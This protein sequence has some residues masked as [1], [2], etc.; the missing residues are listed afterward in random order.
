MHEFRSTGYQ[1]ARTFGELST[2][3]LASFELDSDDMSE[4]FVKQ[5]YGNTEPSIRHYCLK[6]KYVQC[7]RVVLTHAWSIAAGIT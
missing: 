3:Q 4:R 6:L 1:F 5:F 7:H 2:I